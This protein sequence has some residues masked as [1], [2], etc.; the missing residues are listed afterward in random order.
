VQSFY[1]QTGWQQEPDAQ[2]DDAHRFEDLRPVAAEYLHTCRLRTRTAIPSSGQ[3]LLDVASGPVQYPE[4]L[5]YAQGYQYRVCADISVVALQAARRRLDD[6]GQAGIYVLADITR[7]PFANGAM[8]ATISLHTVYHVHKDLQAQ[9]LRELDR[10]T[11]TGG[12][13]AVVYNWGWHAWLMHV[14]LAPLQAARLVQRMLK[15][16]RWRRAEAGGSAAGLGLYFY[17]HSY[18]W[19]RQQAFPFAWEIHP[20]RS[21]HTHASRVYAHEGLGG[22]ALLRWVAR[23]EMRHPRFFARWGTYPLI[24]WQVNHPQNDGTRETLR[25]KM[26]N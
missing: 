2:F 20:W 8:S 16:A 7:L 24:G 12:Q 26:A 6:A 3:F 25:S 9:A 18:G 10:V 13:V 19:F 15:A 22:R 11:H 4:Y 5:T 23:L 1:D 17:A 14:L 21:L